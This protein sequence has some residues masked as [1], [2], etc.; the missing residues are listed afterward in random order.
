MNSEIN[1]IPSEFGSTAVSLGQ[2]LAKARQSSGLSI[3]EV[4][5]RTNRPVTYLE[6][7]EADNFSSFT[8]PAMLRGV[9]SQYVKVVGADHT[10][11]MSLLPN[12]F[13]PTGDLNSVGLKE[14]QT[15]TQ[16]PSAIASRSGLS[17]LG[18]AL[19][20]VVVLA[21][22]AYWVF[23]ARFFKN[24]DEAQK[25][26]PPNQVQVANSPQEP[27]PTAPAAPAP[28]TTPSA[29]NSA[30]TNPTSNSTVTPDTNAVNN[31]Q[32]KFRAPVWVEIKDAKGTVLLSGIQQTGT[33][34]NLSGEP[35]L[36]VKLGDGNNVE[37]NWKGQ[38][39][40]L[41]LLLKKG[42]TVVRIKDLQ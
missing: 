35:P 5:Q 33:E 23:G 40:D 16:P 26:T 20:S 31:L 3:G 28:A 4:A 22:L 24:R 8:S 14:G 42:N 9:V 10:Q 25:L 39:Y 41:S 12:Q 13:K 7:L 27:A 15:L 36:A 2:Y 38:P 34:Q 29:E 21:L 37:M 19:L 1:M 18:I 32:L 6:A 17:K 11:A 30:S